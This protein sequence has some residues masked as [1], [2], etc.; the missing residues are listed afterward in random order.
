[1]IISIAELRLTSPEMVTAIEANVGQTRAFAGCLGVQLLRDLADPA[2]IVLIEQWASP[3]ADDAYR[4]WRR[5]HPA[6]E[7]AQSPLAEPPR[8]TRCEALA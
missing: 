1:M 4:A 3:E 2:R 5:A 8:I 6:D 7:S